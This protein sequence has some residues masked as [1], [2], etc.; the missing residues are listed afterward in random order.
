MKKHPHKIQ[1][2][3]QNNR[4]NFLQNKT[5][6]CHKVNVMD[7]LINCRTESLG[8]HSDH[9]P[10]CDY[11]KISYNSCRNRHCPICQN[12]A[13]EIWVDAR[14]S[15][16]VNA[17]YFH[18][19]FTLPDSLNTLIYNNQKVLYDLMFKCVSQTLIQLSL[20]PNYLGAEIGITAVLHTWGQNLSYHPHIHCIVPGGGLSKSGL[21]F[22]PSSK[23]F[24]LPVKVISSLFKGKFMASLKDLIAKEKI[25]IPSKMS[26]SELKDCLENAYKKSWIVYCKAPFKIPTN[27]I[28]YL[29]RY[30]H[31]VAI[32]D[33]RI[34]SFDDK[35]VTFKY[36]DYRDKNKQK[37]MTL[38]CDE[39]IR[40]FLLHV[41][42]KKFFKIR[43]Y[44]ILSTRTRKTKLLKC[45]KLTNIDLNIIRRHS[46]DELLLSILGKSPRCCPVCGCSH[47]S[48]R[49][50]FTN[51]KRE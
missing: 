24:F 17:P 40:R 11:S 16:L 6:P 47:L 30:S 21:V 29:G 42:P 45:Q 46:K 23:K 20:D 8:H 35:T 32:S 51:V 28:D 33:H 3:L 38:T 25:T 7:S 49:F 9:C 26:A 37:E 22:I 34:L 2:I 44:G 12:L 15:E 1:E 31:K 27:V 43:Y 13:K 41:L 48:R 19:V 10:S 36:R 4:D 18:V 50:V 39:F 14:K 5:L